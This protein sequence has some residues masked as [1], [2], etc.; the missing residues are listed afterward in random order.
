MRQ[1][2]KAEPSTRA[3]SRSSRSTGEELIAKAKKKRSAKKRSTLDDLSY[4]TKLLFS[5]EDSPA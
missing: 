5:R 2:R 3:A 4:R 1:R